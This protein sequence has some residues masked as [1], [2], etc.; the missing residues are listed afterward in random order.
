MEAQSFLLQMSLDWP[1]ISETLRRTHLLF[2]PGIRW[3]APSAGHAA[4]L[5]KKKKVLIFE[6]SMVEEQCGDVLSPRVTQLKSSGVWFTDRQ[7]VGRHCPGPQGTW[8][9]G[10]LCLSL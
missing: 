6:K 1:V 10:L 3:L 2:N 9:P 4:T 8:I 7:V 5:K